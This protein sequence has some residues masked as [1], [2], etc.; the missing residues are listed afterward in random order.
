MTA[1][2]NVP[3]ERT[4]RAA[5]GL[6][7]H[8]DAYVMGL[9]VTSEAKILDLGCGTGAWL[10]RFAERGF[11]NLVGIDIAPPDLP[12]PNLVFIEGDLNQFGWAEQI[13]GEF[14]LVTCIEVIEHIEN[15]GNFVRNV[16]IKIGSKG[17]FIV[18][19]P[20]VASLRARLR[21]L[22]T[23]RLPHFDERGDPTHLVPIYPPAFQRILRR[24]N[25]KISRVWSFPNS[26]VRGVTSS[27]ALIKLSWL[28]GWLLPDNLPGD[29]LCFEINKC[30]N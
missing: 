4:E 11:C 25:L 23:G 22:I 28:L 2:T 17:V 29:I 30:Q 24:Y 9:G 19:T 26:R 14:E 18:T 27:S 21:Y 5:G 15:L 10:S 7:A 12:P 6:H 16:S 3:E 1:T 8:L 13:T 20:N